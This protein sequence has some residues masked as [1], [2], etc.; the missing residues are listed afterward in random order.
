MKRKKHKEKLNYNNKKQVGLILKKF[1]SFNPNEQI[2]FIIF[3]CNHFTHLSSSMSNIFTFL[4][5]S[6]FYLTQ[7]NKIK[8]PFKYFSC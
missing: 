3:I 6:F 1:G 2:L 4:L 7:I 8:S 5:T